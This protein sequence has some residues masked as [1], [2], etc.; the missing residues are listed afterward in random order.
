MKY[1]LFIVLSTSFIKANSQAK[2]IDKIIALVNDQM[3]LESDLNFYRLKST[4][5]SK[6]DCKYLHKLIID[7]LLYSKALKDSIVI[8]D[9]EVD[10]EL[11]NRLA[12]FINVFGSQ[13]KFEK[14][15]NKTLSELKVD[16]REDI[17]QQMLADRAKNKLLAGMEPTPKDVTDYFK[18]LHKDSIQYYNSEVQL[19]Q[20]VFLPKMS[21]EAKKA[22]KQKAEKIR[23]E[24]ISKESTFATQAILYSD[25]PGTASEG[26]NLGW[27]E[28]GMMVPEFE[29]VAF[30]QPIGNISELIET[31]FGL[32]IIETLEKKNGK[33]K[34][35]HILF[36]IKPDAAGLEQAKN[37]ADSI[38]KSILE[39]KISFQKAVEIYSADKAFKSNGGI[40]MNLKSKNRS[41]L[42]EV[43]DIDPTIS[44]QISN[45]KPGDITTPQAYKT[46]VDQ[47]VGYRIVK[48]ISEMPPHRASL[49]TDY[50]KIKDIVHDKLRDKAMENWLKFYKSYVFVKLEPE[51]KKCPNLSIFN[52]DN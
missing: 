14:Y 43:G 24:L 16:F 26:G 12:Y 8:N 33:V 22:I 4:D 11:S 25:D 52:S 29:Q 42:F 46:L 45:M 17:K 27:I 20:I 9:E 39:N 30:S 31:Q 50:Y 28:H 51:Y 34:V 21:R 37:L 15:Y 32:H 40:L 38:R 3:L 41:T 44:T 49:E 48:V 1:I 2:S 18:N 19:A 7:K 36:S 13:E 5:T 6:N 35:R 23:K 10:A 47:K